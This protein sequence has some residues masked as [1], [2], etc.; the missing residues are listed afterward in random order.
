[1]EQLNAYMDA[2][3]QAA[4]KKVELANK[5]VENAQNVLDAEREARAN[6]YASNVAYAQKELDMAKQNQQKALREQERAQKA[7]QALQTVQQATN[8]VTASA[9]IWSQLG[10]PFAI[11]AIAVMWGSFA[12]AKIKAAQLTSTGS[13]E[14][15]E[16]TVE[17]LQGGSHQSGNDVDLGRKKDGTRRRAEGGEFFAVINKRNSRKYRGVIPD[18]I[19]AFNS[20]TFEQKYMD[21]YKGG[22]DIQLPVSPATDLGNLKN[23]VSAIREQGEHRTYTDGRGTHVVYK[24]LHRVI[25]N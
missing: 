24:N 4:E 16:G 25:L 21:A 22:G 10:F 13:E 12:A 9:L 23:D 8:L 15:G 20:G 11:P 17:L 1:M 5:D 2:W 6:G 3:V 18:V 7:Q 19:R 14:Y